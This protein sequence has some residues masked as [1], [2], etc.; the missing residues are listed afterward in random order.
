MSDKDY[1]FDLD[2]ILREFS[3]DSDKPKASPAAQPK[4]KAVQPKPAAQSRPAAPQQRPAAQTKPAAAQQRPAR[5]AH[6]FQLHLMTDT[7]AGLTQIDTVLFRHG[8]NILMVVGAF[9]ARLQG[10]MVCI[11]HAAF[12]FHPIHAHSL[13]LQVG[14][15]SRRV[16]RQGLIDSNS[17]FLARHQL[18]FEQV[19]F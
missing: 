12:R 17:D 4:P 3:S 14:H 6:P 10:I 16:L 18:A 11:R 8:A 13:Q 7:V 5:L 2:D 19:I 1:G 15:G 9:E